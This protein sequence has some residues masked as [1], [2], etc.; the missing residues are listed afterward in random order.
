M[1][2]TELW[3]CNFCIYY[4][5]LTTVN[6]SEISTVFQLLFLGLYNEG[7]SNVNDSNVNDSS[8]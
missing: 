2:M 5:S 6:E 1:T 3:K 4:A 8:C 7:G